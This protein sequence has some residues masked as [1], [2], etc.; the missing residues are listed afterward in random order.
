M[1]TAAARVVQDEVRVFIPEDTPN[2]VPDFP[3]AYACGNF[4]RL[5]KSL[6]AKGVPLSNWGMPRA[7]LC[8][9]QDGLLL[10]L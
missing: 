6:F 10:L 7:I 3:G 1:V 2:T 4:I 9:S 5:G 8:L